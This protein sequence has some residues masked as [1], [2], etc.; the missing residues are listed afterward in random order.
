MEIRLTSVNKVISTSVRT[1]GRF[2]L[3]SLC[4][5]LATILFVGLSHDYWEASENSIKRIGMITLMGVPLFFGLNFFSKRSTLSTLLLHLLGF[6]FLF[7]FYFFN[8]DLSVDVFFYKY[9]ICLLATH[10]FVAFSWFYKKDEE[11][12]FWQ[13]NKTLFISFFISSIYTSILCLGLIICLGTVD[14]LFKLNLNNDLYSDIIIF[15]TFVFHVNHFLSS[16]PKDIASLN[17]NHD[18]PNGLK[19]LTQYL[20]IPLITFYGVIL[21]FYEF[22]ILF[23]LS[24]PKGSVSFM[25]SMMAV[26]GILNLLLICPKANDLKNKWINTYSRFFYLA[27]IPLI[28]LLYFAIIKRL[29]D[30][31]VTESRYYVLSIAIWLSGICTYF[32]IS[33]SK[34]IRVIPVTLFIF[35]I[36]SSFGPWGATG[37]SI[38]SQFARLEASLEKVNMLTDGVVQ[39]QNKSLKQADFRQ[40]EDLIRYIFKRNGIAPFLNWK[41]TDGKSLTEESNYGDV[42]AFLSAEELTT[43]SY[44]Y[45]GTSLNIPDTKFN[46]SF[47]STHGTPLEIKGYDYHVFFRVFPHGNKY[48][49]QGNGEKLTLNIPRRTNKLEVSLDDKKV[50][51]YDLGKYLKKVLANNIITKRTHRNLKTE[52]RY[53]EMDFPKVKIKLV[54]SGVDG[55]QKDKLYLISEIYGTMLVRFK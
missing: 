38:N 5:I 35:A 33:K 50:G 36:V 40:A 46:F 19:I 24:L 25:I 26:L 43:Y 39:L 30:Y 17:L 14:T 34:N 22:K 49:F 2:P 44:D 23:Q 18:Y 13:F 37:L 45:Y 47:S 41:N 1:I 55:F 29:L 21:Y 31:G 16:I 6:S 53:I 7:G 28:G 54:L 12:G 11:N 48:Y 3:S 27:L 10:L 20:L 52:D 9:V 42:I 51:T 15:C 8:I 32:L 4:S